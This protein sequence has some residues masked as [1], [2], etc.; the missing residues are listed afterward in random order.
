MFPKRL[1]ERVPCRNFTLIELLVVIAIIAILAGMLLPALN[2]ARAT[3]QRISCVNNLANMAKAANMYISD[4]K[5]YLSSYYNN[6]AGK[7]NLGGWSGGAG[8][9]FLHAGNQYGLW[10][11]LY[12]RNNTATLGGLYRTYDGSVIISPLPCPA[13][14]DDVPSTNNQTNCTIGYNSYIMRNSDLK[15]E[16]FPHPSRLFLFG[17][18]N[19][20]FETYDFHWQWKTPGTS[21]LETPD[22]YL[23]FRHNRTMNV[24]C[25]GGNADSVTRNDP[26]AAA[27]SPDCL[28][29]HAGKGHCYAGNDYA[30]CPS[31]K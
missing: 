14:G 17:D 5:G 10:P 20:K 9:T 27:P 24:V 31:C 18:R 13:A 29:W 7:G 8:T 6:G 2:S 25:L 11:Y 12:A 4:N 19:T 1:S 16:L 28:A 3:A 23:T 26:R 21:P 30:V 15:A 22:S